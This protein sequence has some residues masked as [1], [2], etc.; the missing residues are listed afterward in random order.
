MASLFAFF[1]LTNLCQLLGLGHAIPPI[2]AA[3]LPNALAAAVGL[4]FF[5]RSL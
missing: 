1:L 4:C 5:L 2:A 3:W